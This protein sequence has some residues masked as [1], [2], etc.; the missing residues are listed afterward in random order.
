M[1]AAAASSINGNV[2]R[3][4]CFLKRGV[5]II[6]PLVVCAKQQRAV[7]VLSSPAVKTSTPRFRKQSLRL[8][9]VMLDA[10][11][12]SI[13]K[14]VDES[15]RIVSAGKAISYPEYSVPWLRPLANLFLLFSAN[16]YF[17]FPR[18]M[19]LP[20]GSGDSHRAYNS[21]HIK[22]P[23]RRLP[24]RRGENLRGRGGT[25]ALLNLKP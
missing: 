7:L 21:F 25:D 19:F 10:A 3:K 17:S 12:A 20:S 9:C 23:F 5:G 22:R 11:A 2:R 13:V 24:L 4:D 1:L 14:G 18:K 6:H 15:A 16:A 8:T